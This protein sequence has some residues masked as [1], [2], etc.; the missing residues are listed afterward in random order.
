MKDKDP[1][2]VSWK[3]MFLFTRNGNLQNTDL[4]YSFFLGVVFLFVNFIIANRLTILF[5]SLLPSAS[6]QMK[7]GLD[8]VIPSLL[9]LLITW[10]LFRVIRRK[11][12][13]FMACCINLVIALVFL[14]AMVFLYDRE[15]VTMLL[16]PFTGIFVIPAAICTGAAWLFYRHW[17]RQNPDPIKEEERDLELRSR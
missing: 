10:I 6:R 12:I 9:S 15:T 8:I 1:A 13:V 3:Q 4:L 2:K 5:E 14:A 11:R 17:L 16:P 7:N